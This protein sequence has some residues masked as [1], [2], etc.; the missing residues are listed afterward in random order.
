MADRVAG[1]LERRY[2]RSAYQA[3]EDLVFCDPVLGTVRVHTGGA[4]RRRWWTRR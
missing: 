2:Q 1:E 4:S 3:D